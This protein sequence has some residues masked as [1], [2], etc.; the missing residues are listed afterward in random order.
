VLSVPPADLAAAFDISADDLDRA[1]LLLGGD[2]FDVDFWIDED[3]MIRRVSYQDVW[4]SDTGV[5]PTEAT[6][7]LELVDYGVEFDAK[8]PP[9]TKV[10]E[11]KAFDRLVAQ[12]A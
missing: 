2:A 11:A 6:F 3:G 10:M 8:R 1:L 4:P 9:R 7:T 5:P 12:S